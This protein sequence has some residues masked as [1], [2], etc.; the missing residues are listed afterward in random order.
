MQLK[1]LLDGGANIF[2]R[3][4]RGRTAVDHI[5]W[6]RPLPE[7]HFKRLAEFKRNGLL[8]TSPSSSKSQNYHDVK[9]L[10][11]ALRGLDDDNELLGLI[12]KFEE[13]D[14]ELE[15]TAYFYEDGELQF[16]GS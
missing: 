6:L 1:I 10:I 14:E 15:P 2:I 13:F 4:H 5:L 7:G 12:E 8:H 11:L 9:M 3:D 16:A